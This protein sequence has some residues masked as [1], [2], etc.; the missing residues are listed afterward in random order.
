M[1]EFGLEAIESQAPE[2]VLIAEYDGSERKDY[3]DVRCP[4]IRGPTSTPGMMSIRSS[5]GVSLRSV[6]DNLARDQ[7]MMVVNNTGIEDKT[8]ITQE[9]ANFK[10]AKGMELAEKWCK[11]NFGITFRKEQRRM[12]VWIVRKKP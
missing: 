10:T 1:S 4:A 3:R 6:L 9:V 7:E 12:P 5:Q 8:I 2:T 11:D